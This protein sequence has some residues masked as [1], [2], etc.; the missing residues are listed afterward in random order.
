MFYTAIEYYQGK[1]RDTLVRLYTSYA[2]ECYLTN[3]IKEAIIFQG[4]ALAIWKEKHEVEKIGD[5]MWFL[6]RLWWFDGNRKQ[7]EGYGHQAIEVLSAR[8]SSRAKAMAY[9]NMSQLKMLSDHIVE[10]IH[11][12][13][14]AIII[15][16]ELGD[17]EILSHALNSVGAVQMRVPAYRERGILLLKRSLELALKH[18]Y[19][20]LAAQCLHQPQQRRHKDQRLRIRRRDPE[21]GHSIL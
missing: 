15:A 14:N 11:W 17:D 3:R 16:N 21:A 8:P 1:D 10:C 2:Y 4:K 7:A 12:G 19:H 13:E 9:S 18:G 6:S 5:S 20:E